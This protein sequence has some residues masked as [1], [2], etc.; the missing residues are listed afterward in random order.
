MLRFGLVGLLVSACSMDPRPTWDGESEGVAGETPSVFT[1]DDGTVEEPV[2]SN[3][4]DDQGIDGGGDTFVPR[5]EFVSRATTFW[6]TNAVAVDQDGDEGLM[7]MVGGGACVVFPDDGDLGD[8]EDV[9]ECP[10][11]PIAYFANGNVLVAG[12][13]CDDVSVYAGNAQVFDVEIQGLVTVDVMGDAIVSLEQ[14]FGG[15]C[16]LVTRDGRDVV[17][18]VELPVEACAAGAAIVTDADAGAIYV[19]AGSLW[20]VDGDSARLIADDAGDRLALD[21]STGTLVAAW[22]D[23]FQ[24]SAWSVDGTA[25]WTVDTEGAVK[26]LHEV[27]DRGVV[28]A[29]LS[30]RDDSVGRFLALGSEDGSLWGEA[31]AWPQVVDIDLS[32]DGRAMLVATGT[33]TVYS[34]GV[35]LLD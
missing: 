21:R 3:D 7:G 35:R 13:G 27:G 22:T 26:R 8:E 18:A 19:A 10:D 33:G 20:A 31:I 25:L 14:P 6:S 11:E 4:G 9:H 15:D 5:I 28:V 29:H 32:A 30:N 24:V 12:I 1:S 2:A 17:D 16:N 23:S 34:Y